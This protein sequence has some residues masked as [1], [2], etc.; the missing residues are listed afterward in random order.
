VYRC[1]AQKNVANPDHAHKGWDREQAKRA[2]KVQEV[3]TVEAA[4]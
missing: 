2:H 3:A 1:S 4:L